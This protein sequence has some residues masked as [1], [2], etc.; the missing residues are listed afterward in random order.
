[1]ELIKKLLPKYINNNCIS[2][3]LFLC[4]YCSKEVIKK[5]SDGKK[6]K[7]CGCKKDE[8]ISKS[9]KGKKRTNEQKLKIRNNR[10]YQKGQNS[11]MYGKKLT[12]EAK[13]KISIANKGKKRTE[14]I[15]KKLSK[16]LE[17]RISPNKGKINS[18]EYKQKM[19]ERMRGSNHWNWQGG[20]S[21]ETYP[22]EFKQIRKF[23]LKRDNYKCQNI[24]CKSE[25]KK[26]AI[27][28]IDYNKKNNSEK[29]LITLGFSCH[30]KTNY[31]REYWIKYYQNIIKI[32]NE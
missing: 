8:L 24:E 2:Y 17:G 1:M 27:H 10:R 23:I 13:L 15:K 5:L 20:K 22:Q 21:F 12:E 18:E 7:S 28:H 16:S 14:E 19:S 9:N 11:P 6:Q 25:H 31:N 29:N 26:L 3:G 4:F 30:L 32:K